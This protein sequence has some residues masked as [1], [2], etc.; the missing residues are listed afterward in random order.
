MAAIIVHGGAWAIPDEMRDECVRGCESAA[1][2]GY[3]V[4]LKGGSSLD[5][6]E[7]S[8]RNL[9][10]N[11]VLNCG[12]GSCL[13]SKKEVEMDAIIVSGEDLKF[14]AV[15]S[16]VNI[17]HPISLARLVL[18]KTDHVFLIGKGANEF[19]AAMGISEVD[20]SHLVTERACKYWEEYHKYKSVIKELFTGTQVEWDREH[21]TVGVVAMDIH[22]NLAA[23]TSTGGITYKMP[24]RVG[25][26]PLIGCGASCD[27]E[28]GGVS[29]TGHGEAIAKVTLCQRILTDISFSKKTGQKAAEDALSYMKQRVGGYGGAIGITKH[30]E[31]FKAYSTKRMAWSS[32]DK[33]GAQSSG[34]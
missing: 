24:G 8:V 20:Q 6:V 7:T 16:V 12:R 23:G 15:A 13:T 22:G 30:G 34:S 11:P 18:D 9:E 19:A 3:E 26:S 14:G 4:L 31:V 29:T 2:E 27:N 32:I 1:R 10:D 17:A 21:D 28:V 5:A 33:S 25:D